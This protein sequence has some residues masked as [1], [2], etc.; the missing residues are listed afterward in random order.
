MKHAFKRWIL[1]LWIGSSFAVRGM[2]LKDGDKVAFITGQAFELWSWSPSGYMRLLTDKLADAGIKKDP[3]VVLERVTTTQMLQRV[4][5]DVIAKAPRYAIIIPGTADYNAWTE[6]VVAAEFIQ[7]LAGVIEKLQAAKI[8]PILVTTYPAP[9]NLSLGLNKNVADHN[10][11]IRALAQEKNVPLIDF[12]QAVD[13][14]T[15]V[16]PF[17][18]NPVAKCLVNQIF[19]GEVLRVLGFEHQD[20]VAARAAWL[21]MPGAIKLMPAVSVNNYE[22]LKAA[23]KAAGKTVEAQMTGVLHDALK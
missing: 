6:R 23:A 17:D 5:D 3:L 21:E 8:K 22:K 15:K 2:D 19:A 20:I 14:E 9:S 13:D 11:A 16:V 12:A 18:G 10:E 7:N 4:D 1:V